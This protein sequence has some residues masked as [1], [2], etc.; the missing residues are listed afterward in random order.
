MLQLLTRYSTN[1]GVESSK[2]MAEAD[3]VAK[4]DVDDAGGGGVM[5]KSVGV[6]KAMSSC[7]LMICI[8]TARRDGFGDV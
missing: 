6:G 7:L 8:R 4:D 3:A 5:G 1:V 2:A